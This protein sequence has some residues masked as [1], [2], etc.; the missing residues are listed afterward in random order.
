[1]GILYECAAA[2]HAALDHFSTRVAR[3]AYGLWP[4]VRRKAVSSATRALRC[5]VWHEI[6]VD[7]RTDR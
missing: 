5:R 2:G 4:V 1:M 6:R 3:V 7:K